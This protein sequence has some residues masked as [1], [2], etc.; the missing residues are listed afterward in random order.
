MGQI[1]KQLYL[2]HF[3]CSTATRDLDHVKRELEEARCRQ[4]DATDGDDK[5]YAVADC[6]STVLCSTSASPL[7]GEE[8]RSVGPSLLR[9]TGTLVEATSK[10]SRE[11]EAS[12][13]TVERKPISATQRNRYHRTTLEYVRNQL[14]FVGV[15]L[16]TSTVSD[17]QESE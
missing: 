7:T 13:I 14:S 5:H 8:N 15:I 6:P 11:D 16:R 1:V 2:R 3:L 9:Y 17:S 10:G 4:R 12:E